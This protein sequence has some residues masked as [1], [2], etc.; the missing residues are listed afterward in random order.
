ME[1]D[2]NANDHQ[3]GKRPGGEVDCAGVA[4]FFILPSKQAKHGPYKSR[5]LRRS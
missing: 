5:S 4:L 2:R 3:H 1:V